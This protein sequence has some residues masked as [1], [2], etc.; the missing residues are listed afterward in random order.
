VNP[1][2]E[3]NYT[4]IE[5]MK[6]TTDNFLLIGALLLLISVFAGKVAYRFGAPALLLFLGVGML[7]GVQMIAFDSAV[8]AQFVGMTALCIILFSGG[9]DTRLRSIRPVATP[10]VALATVGVALTAGIVGGFV[11]LLSEVWGLH[12]SLL[13]TLLLAATMSSTDSASVFSILRSRRKGLTE[14]LQPLLELESGSNDPMAYMLTLFCIGLL[15]PVATS[16]FAMSLLR[17]VVGMVVGVASGYGFGRLSVWTLNRL[18]ITNSSLYAVL[19]LAFI[20]LTFSISGVL[21]GN[22]YL[23]VYVAGLIV[24]NRPLVHKRML[25]NFFEG[26]TWL[27][28]VILFVTLGLLVD[29]H[30]LLE[31]T[32][33]VVGIVTGLFLMFVARPIAVFI[34]LL[35]FRQ[36]SRKARLYISW[37]GLRG[38]VPII[39]ATYPI[40]ADIEGA[41]WIFNVV[42]IVTLLSLAVQGTTVSLMA[43]W[44]GLARPEEERTFNEEVLDYMLDNSITEISVN[45]EMLA[46]GGL[47]SNIP[48]P[49][50]TLVM[51][52]ARDGHF[53]VP[54]GDSRLQAGDKLLIISDDHTRMST[55]PQTISD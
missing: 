53:F 34:T 44:L 50:A 9:M 12:L 49:S 16:S 27:F 23:A 36:L 4:P 35:P 13:T 28:Q 7:F 17:F 8:V 20:Y 40:V 18:N 10:G 33:L 52:V 55:Q 37:V 22:G 15:S 29:I 38:A 5:A 54:Q 39:F 19:L 25:G 30:D 14:H 6:L 11:Y 3:A 26:L 47:L 24:G 48:L 1:F 43:E 42:F 31:P 32:T 45:E 21:Q 2:G 41:T 46:Q 51:M